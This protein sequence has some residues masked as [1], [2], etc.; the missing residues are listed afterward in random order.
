MSSRSQS[1]VCT[2]ASDDPTRPRRRVAPAAHGE[3]ARDQHVIHAARLAHVAAGPAR[4]IAPE[5]GATRI[6]RLGVEH[7][8]VGDRARLDAPALAQAEEL[9]GLAGEAVHALL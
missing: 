1:E 4:E 6:D 2:E 7:H 3:L 8:Q 5:D 9:G